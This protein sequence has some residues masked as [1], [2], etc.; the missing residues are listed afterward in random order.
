MHRVRIFTT[1][2]SSDNQQ[3]LFAQ[4]GSIS[5][6]KENAIDIHANPY[7]DM[8][9]GTSMLLQILLCLPD[10]LPSG[11]SHVTLKFDGEIWEIIGTCLVPTRASSSGVSLSAPSHLFQP[12]RQSSTSQ[13]ILPGD[14]GSQDT[15]VNVSSD[16]E[17]DSGDVIV[18]PPPVRPPIQEIDL[19]EENDAAENDTNEQNDVEQDVEVIPPPPN[20][21]PPSL[22]SP[23]ASTSSAVTENPTI[24][25]DFDILERV[26]AIQ[27]IRSFLEDQNQQRP[28]NWWDEPNNATQQQQNQTNVPNHEPVPGPSSNATSNAS[29]SRVQ[30]PENQSDT[31]A[32]KAEGKVTND[33]HSQKMKFVEE[34]EEMLN[35]A[36]QTL[37]DTYAKLNKFDPPIGVQGNFEIWHMRMTDYD[38]KYVMLKM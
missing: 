22:F 20:F 11:N 35:N 10:H 18:L 32:K 26:R 28:Q 9:Q 8:I 16:S 17:D 21:A 38:R 3:V 7:P 37:F 1:L 33:V 34:L 13:R 12:W 2:N 36:P 6:P 23:P 19:T 30:V 31:Q 4:K 15:P 5:P 27:R 29:S 24:A 25:S 14:S